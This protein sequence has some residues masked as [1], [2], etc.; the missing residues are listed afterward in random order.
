[1]KRL[2]VELSDFSSYPILL[3]DNSV[4]GWGLTVGWDHML[5]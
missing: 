3:A 4:A 2:N 5:Q 1:M